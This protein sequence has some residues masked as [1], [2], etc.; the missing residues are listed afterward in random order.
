[1]FKQLYNSRLR[2]MSYVEGI[3]LLLL[4][5]IGVPLKYGSGQP[6]LVEILGPIHGVAFLVFC[7]LLL[8]AF[9][10]EGLKFLDALIVFIAAFIPFGFL[11]VR[12]ILREH[13][14]KS[15]EN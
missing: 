7:L 14:K 15:A 11:F 6:H 5:L 12:R 2:I 3:S 9:V 8:L 1:M 13:E 4:V 10:G